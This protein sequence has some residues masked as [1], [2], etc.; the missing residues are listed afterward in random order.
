V[1]HGSFAGVVFVVV[2]LRRHADKQGYP[3]ASCETYRAATSGGE[4]QWMSVA[5]AKLRR[6]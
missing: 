6:N 2:V 1:E 5:S 4:V 3:G